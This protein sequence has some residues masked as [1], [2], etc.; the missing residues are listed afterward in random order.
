M[1]GQLPTLIFLLFGG[2][3]ADRVDP[4]RLLI[5]IQGAGI[6]MPLILA[7]ALWR[8]GAGEAI[9]L[10]YAVAWGLVSAFAM[11]A[12]DGLLKRVAGNRIQH[13][14]TLAIGT[15][16]G[17]QMIGQALGGSAQTWG[18]IG[19]LLLQCGVLAAGIFTASQL[20]AA[21]GTTPAQTALRGSLWSE[22]SAGL[23]MI[24]A[25]RPMRACYILICGMGV[26]FGGVF[27]VLVPLIL[28]DVYSGS[29]GDIA[30]AYLAF[31]SGTLI[32][33]V[34][35]TRKGGIRLPGRALVVSQFG[36]CLMLL[37]LVFAPPKPVFYLCVF[38]WGMCGGV[39]MT[40]SR[41]IMQERAPASHQSRVMAAY[42]LATAGGGPLGSLVL[43]YA[44]QLLSARWAVL[45]PII[46]VLG[47]TGGALLSHPIWR[48][49]SQSK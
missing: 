46:G 47:A 16:F 13:M 38:F 32:T 35:M 44:V 7:V 15:Q 4:R 40:M 42:S 22:F 34:T 6:V 25:D 39:A 18:A 2:W 24:H 5:A 33:I 14:V 17:A 11:P 3:L 9:L 23:S 45:V 36:G 48:L 19:I 43:G 1:F 49:K 30:L 29:A 20:P 10:L 37:P 26:F 8:G 28:R 12:R 41:T 31:G 21:A 27:I